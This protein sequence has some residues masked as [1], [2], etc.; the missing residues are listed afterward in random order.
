MNKKMM[1]TTELGDFFNRHK[2]QIVNALPSHFKPDR[3]IR[4]ALSEFGK[5][6]DLKTCSPESIFAS[7][8]LASQCGLE[9]GV[10]GQAYLI[11]Y[12]GRCTFVPGWRGLLNLVT[13]TGQATCWTGAAFEG[14]SFEYMLGSE[15]YVLHK[16]GRES[17]PKKITHV[18]SIGHQNG[19]QSRIV[20][21][22][23]IDKIWDHRD[24]F[25]KVGK[26]HYS[27]T[28]PEMYARKVPLLQVIKYL[29]QSVELQIAQTQDHNATTGVVHDFINGELVPVDVADTKAAQPTQGEGA[30][31]N[32]NEIFENE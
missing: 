8:I 11:P 4:L 1:T 25:N 24:K 29:P 12:K 28:N 10:L 19:N 20:E 9:I 21:V 23:P 30:T 7:V 13:R 2:A 22:W 3:M 16:P 26:S 18:Y 5:N 31:A 14:D 15:P 32:A 17:D 6:Q 27:F